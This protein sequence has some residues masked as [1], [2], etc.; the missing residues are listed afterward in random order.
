[1][2]LYLTFSSH[3]VGSVLLS[4][5]DRVFTVM[6]ISPWDL[7]IFT[8]FLQRTFCHKFI[9]TRTPLTLTHRGGPHTRGLLSNESKLNQNRIKTKFNQSTSKWIEIELNQSSNLQKNISIQNCEPFWKNCP[10]R[11]NFTLQTPLG[12]K[13]VLQGTWRFRFLPVPLP[14][15]FDEV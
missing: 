2:T 4:I 10:K 7:V 15:H 6:P 13:P 5:A 9:F 1:M 8:W 3:S 14:S 11:F 12:C